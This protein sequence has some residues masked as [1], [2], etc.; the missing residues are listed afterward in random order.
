MYKIMNSITI[1]DIEVVLGRKSFGREPFCTC[2][3]KNHKE[4][5]ETRYFKKEADALRD[6]C[7]RSLCEVN[8]HYPTAQTI[9]TDNP[10]WLAIK[11]IINGA[12][13]LLPLSQDEVFDVFNEQAYLEILSDRICESR[14]EEE[15]RYYENL[16]G[17]AT[18]RVDYKIIGSLEDTDEMDLANDD[19]YEAEM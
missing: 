1:G 16:K 13:Y 8:S 9:S 3:C 17:E 4:Y 7:E 11:R 19:E 10:S 12:E 14:T 2:Y 6:F 18:M 15:L 5:Y